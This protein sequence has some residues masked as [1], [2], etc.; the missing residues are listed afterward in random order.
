MID[1]ASFEFRRARTSRARRGAIG[2]VLSL[3]LLKLLLR[4]HGA[5]GIG[6]S[7]FVHSYASYRISQQ[8]IR[9]AG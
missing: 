5:W 4:S 2:R 6:S 1:L 8:I 9:P 3:V 7:I